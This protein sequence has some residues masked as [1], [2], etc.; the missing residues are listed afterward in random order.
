MLKFDA[1]QWSKSEQIPRPGHKASQSSHSSNQ[2]IDWGLQNN[3]LERVN[4]K[5]LEETKMYNDKKSR[6]SNR[7]RF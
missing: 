2:V 4:V 5:R 1:K 3:M 6:K 7:D